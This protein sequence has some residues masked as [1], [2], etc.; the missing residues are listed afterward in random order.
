MFCMEI[1][2]GRKL[3][4]SAVSET[5]FRVVYTGKEEVEPPSGIVEAR[6]LSAEPEKE[7]KEGFWRLSYGKI[8]AEIEKGSGIISW[9]REDSGKKLLQEG[10]KS[11]TPITLMKYQLEGEKPV[12]DHVHTVDG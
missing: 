10:E 11:L 3:F 4:V 1:S 8:R 7:E 6:A 12:I 9:F 2:E 5:V